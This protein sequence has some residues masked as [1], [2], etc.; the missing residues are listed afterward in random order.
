MNVVIIGGTGHIGQFLCS[1][2]ADRGDQVIVISSGKTPITDTRI[3]AVT[4]QYNQMIDDGSFDK[5]LRET[6]PHAV[7]DILQD[8]TPALYRIVQEAGIK[9]MVICGSVWMFGRPKIV[10]T[11]PVPQTE[12][13]FPGYKKR[14]TE[15][16]HSIDQARHEGYSLSAIMPPNICGPGKIPLDGMGGRDIEIHRQH[17]AGKP[18]TLPYP[19]SN[20]IGPCDAED[21]ARAFFCALNN[22]DKS[23]GHIF[24]VGSAYAL[25][26]EQFIRTY[27]EIYRTTIPI[28]Y[29]SMEKYISEVSP[30]L[31][32]NFHFTDHMCPDISKT[33]DL[34]GYE[35]KYTPE[36]TM[37]RA[38]KWM[39]DQKLL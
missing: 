6:R 20:L 31:G 18:V 12:C 9:Q 26:S 3:K 16:V 32:S 25:T 21:V 29:V 17:Q 7:V 5:L 38:V 4:L 30:D 8:H 34:L 13:P 36:E 14:F 33:T 1:M 23:A 22:P 37:A 2:L 39:Y 35:P 24:N 11:P 27:A 10:P 28:N 15:M 19:G